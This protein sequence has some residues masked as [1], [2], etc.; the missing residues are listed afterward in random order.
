MNDD[1][2]PPLPQNEESVAYSTDN[3]MVALPAR[4]IT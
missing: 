1:S 2:Y 4:T 3:P